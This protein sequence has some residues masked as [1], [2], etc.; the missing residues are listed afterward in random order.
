MKG[1]A[2]GFHP[3]DVLP[4]GELTLLWREVYANYPVPL[5]FTEDELARFI[6]MSGIDL[7]LSQVATVDDVPVGLSLAACHDK[8]GWSDGHQAGS[9]DGQPRAAS[10]R[11]CRL[12]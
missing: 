10:L 7:S 3:A 11:R 6:R 2:I 5:P 4:L 8:A 9:H 1:P 12:R